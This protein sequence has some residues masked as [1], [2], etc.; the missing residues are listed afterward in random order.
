[1]KQA[2]PAAAPYSSLLLERL[3]LRMPGAEVLSLTLHRHLEETESVVEHRHAFAQA[4]IYLTG[5]GHQTIEGKPH[6]IGAGSLVMLPPR[7]K[8]A[9]RRGSSRRPL[10]L[11]VDFRWA[12]AR[13][14]KPAVL[15]LASGEMDRLRGD[16]AELTRREGAGGGRLRNLQ[17]AAAVL[18]VLAIAL[19]AAGWA[20]N[21]A[22]PAHPSPNPPDAL[23]VWLRDFPP[24]VGLAEL[25]R[26]SGYHRDHLNRLARRETGLTLGQLRAR[27]RLEEA[28]R[29]LTAGWKVGAV[30]TAAGFP[31]QNYFARWFRRQTGTTP[32]RWREQA[33]SGIQD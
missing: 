8:H 12:R 22:A 3:R 17:S 20:E 32:T 18:R 14:A 26:R 2:I 30:A 31:D 1:M 21:T 9:F 25:A 10:C 15:K 16:L 19:E 33:L 28:R 7:V 29:L 11:V 23:S 13:R 24:E 5:A 6:E 4:I 27:R